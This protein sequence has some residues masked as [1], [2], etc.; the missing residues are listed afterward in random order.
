MAGDLFMSH[1]HALKFKFLSKDG[2]V[3]VHMLKF[4]EME[5][6]Y[7][8]KATK[9]DRAKSVRCDS[10]GWVFSGLNCLTVPFPSSYMTLEQECGTNPCKSQAN[11]S[12][13]HM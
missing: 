5:K 6:G 9:E 7:F 10:A 3:L 4:N 11:S 8:L 12:S 1:R 13:D 2:M